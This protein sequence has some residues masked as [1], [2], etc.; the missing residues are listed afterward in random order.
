MDRAPHNR[1]AMKGAAIPGSRCAPDDV[2]YGE[3][4]KAAQKAAGTR[5]LLCPT[6]VQP[7]AGGPSSRYCRHPPSVKQS[8][9]FK[10]KDLSRFYQAERINDGQKS[11]LGVLHQTSQAQVRPSDLYF[12]LDHRGGCVGCGVGVLWRHL[13]PGHVPQWPER[14]AWNGDDWVGCSAGNGGSR[15]CGGRRRFVGCLG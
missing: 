4:Q 11:S 5:G 15:R 9:L 3:C 7:R 8:A 14:V 10:F 6:R 12:R 2:P 13:G 1:C